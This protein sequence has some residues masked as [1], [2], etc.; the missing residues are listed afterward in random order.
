QSRPR[1]GKGP[2]S[3][4]AAYPLAS[5]YLPGGKEA[6]AIYRLEA[7]ASVDAAFRW[8]TTRVY[9]GIMLNESELVNAVNSRGSKPT[10]GHEGLPDPPRAIMYTHPWAL[11]EMG[12]EQVLAELKSCGF[13]A[14]QL[15][16]SYHVASFLM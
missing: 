7:T 12:T 3:S 11:Q 1:L 14:I 6:R 15:S 13:D 5:S 2:A 4:W 10:P 16:F 9:I 8:Y